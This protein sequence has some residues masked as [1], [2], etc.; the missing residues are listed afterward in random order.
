MLLVNSRIKQLTA[1]FAQH[2]IDAF[3]V[4]KDVNITYLTNFPA[5]ESWLFVTPQKSFYIT[6]FRYILEAQ[7]GLKGIAIKQ[8]TKSIYQTLFETAA[9]Q[10]IKS[11]GFDDRHITLAQYRTLTEKCPKTIKLVP[12][13]N[14]VENFREIKDTYEVNQVKKALKVHADTLKFLKGVIKPGVTEQDVFLKLENYVKSRG[15]GFSFSPIIAS[16]PNSCYPHA[17]VTNRKIKNNEPVLIDIG[18]DVNGYKSDLTRMF[19]LG[20][21]TPLVEKV[22][23]SVRE[24]Q[25]IAIAKIKAGISVADVDR[26][27]RNSLAKNKLDQYFGHSLGHGVGLEIHENPRLSQNSNAI[28]KEG[29]I[30]TVEPGVYLPNK[31]GIR[32]EDMV[33]VQ[34]DKGKVLSGNI[35]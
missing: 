9:E 26:E 10:K 1:T 18:I 23:A 22:N 30:V 2:K 5:S 20:R 21:I 24:A 33:L 25:Q 13:S 32:I 8:Y 11:I 7:R 31:F 15:C 28:L 3:L 27:A 4:V 35:D 17:K 14:L 19:F 34:K 29:M 12:T 6:D 16:G